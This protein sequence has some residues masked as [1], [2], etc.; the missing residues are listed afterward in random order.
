VTEALTEGL[1]YALKDPEAGVDIF[2]KEIPEMGITAGGKENARISQ[3]LMHYTVISK[4]AE[5]QSLGYTDMTKA[6]EM[7]DMVMEFGAPKD[8][9]KPDVKQL[10]SNDFTDSVKLSAAEW[11]KVKKN[12][13][14][15]ATILG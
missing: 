14:E 7:I 4:E 15:Y 8:A 10:F 12:V 3:A 9:K 11:A 6:G 13:A 5:T 1:A 2:L